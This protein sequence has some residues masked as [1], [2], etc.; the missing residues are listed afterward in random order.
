MATTVTG[1][2]AHPSTQTDGKRKQI[3]DCDCTA[4]SPLSVWRRTRIIRIALARRRRPS[5]H[6]MRDSKKHTGCRGKHMMKTLAWIAITLAALLAACSSSDSTPTTA[7]TDFLSKCKAYYGAWC[8]K[9][10]S[11]NS[12]SVTSKYSSAP[13][14]KQDTAAQV[15][16]WGNALTT[17]AKLADCAHVCDQSTPYTQNMSCATFESEALNTLH[18]GT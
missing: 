9:G 10:F 6:Q 3:G 17:D 15:D 11:C 13:S 7:K 14:C 16:D 4:E 2:A 18:C 1:W 12:A 8:D 5:R